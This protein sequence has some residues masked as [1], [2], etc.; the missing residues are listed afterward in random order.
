MPLRAPEQ[1]IEG[2]DRLHE[3]HAVLFGGKPLVDFQERH[4][5][6]HLPQIP[7]RGDAADVPFHGL[8]E[9]DRCENARAVKRRAGQHP[10]PHGVDQVEHLGVGAVAVPPD[11]VLG[12]RLGRAA[13]ALVKGSEKAAAGPDLLGLGS[14]HPSLFWHQPYRAGPEGMTGA[15][16]R[17]IT[18]VPRARQHLPGALHNRSPVTLRK[19]DSGAHAQVAA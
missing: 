7:R 12:Q 4:H 13:A 3:L 6:L 10:G 16:S 11:A 5:V 14:V 18:V 15:I 2:I 1:I 8:L 19:K 17:A 9:Q